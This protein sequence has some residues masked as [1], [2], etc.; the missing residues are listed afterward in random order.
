MRDMADSCATL[1]VAACYTF[2]SIARNPHAEGHKN[3]AETPRPRLPH[4]AADHGTAR[5]PG[6]ALDVTHHVGAARRRADL[7]RAPRR[8]RRGLADGAEPAAEG[9]ARGGL[10]RAWR[11]GR[12]RPDA[13]RPRA[14][15]NIA[16]ALSLR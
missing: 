11:S 3:H 8:L 4:R 1:S 2:R 12:L 14:P 7:A 5:S 13:A 6:P 15:C 10:R 16:A 9:L